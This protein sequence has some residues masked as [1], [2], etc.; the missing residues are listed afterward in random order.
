MGQGGA[1]GAT[2]AATKLNAQGFIRY[3][4]RPADQMPAY[5]EKVISDQELTDVFAFIKS[6]PPAKSIDQI[7]LLKSLR[8]GH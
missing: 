1:A 8:E 3:A 7:P 6:V 4:R 2:L 5:T